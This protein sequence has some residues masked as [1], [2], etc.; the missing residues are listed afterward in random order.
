[1]TIRA[2]H[3]LKKHTFYSILFGRHNR[4]PTISKPSA[5]YSYFADKNV[6]LSL[7]QRYSM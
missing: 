6:A 7:P 2:Y 5:L 1:M 4:A 3:P